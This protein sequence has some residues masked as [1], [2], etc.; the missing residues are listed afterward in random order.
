MEREVAKRYREDLVRKQTSLRYIV[1]ALG[2]PG[3]VSRSRCVEVTGRRTWWYQRE[4]LV[5][6]NRQLGLRINHIFAQPVSAL[7]QRI[8]IV[9]AWMHLHP[10]RVVL[11]RRR[12][13]IPDCLKSSLLVNLLVAPHAVCPHIGAVEVCLARVKYH[14]VDGGLVA[15]FVVLNVL[16]EVPGGVDGEDVAVAGVVVEGV[17][18][19]GVRGLLGWEEEDGAGLCRGIVGFGCSE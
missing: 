19:D 4:G 3:S 9:S 18:V 14:A 8:Q 17:A 16:D 13:G 5:R 11:W 6:V 15:V 2:M 12:F 10:P 7:H 1:V